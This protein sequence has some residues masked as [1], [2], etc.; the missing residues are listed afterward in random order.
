MPVIDIDRET[1]HEAAQRELANPIYP[2]A[3]LSDRIAEWFNDLLYRLMHTGT[4]L[5]GGWFTM[6]VLGLLIL[7]ALIVAVRIA[8]RTMGRRGDDPLHRSLMLSA[9]D[10]RERAEH[11]AAQQDWATAIRQRLRAVSRQLEEDGVLNPVPGRTAGE[12]AQD[13]GGMMPTYADDLVAAAAA[14]DDVTYGR[15]PGTEPQYRLIVG[16]DD[17]VRHH[18]AGRPA[19]D[20]PA[21]AR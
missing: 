7:A 1:A 2:R 12:L 18:S 8:R 13:A 14:F 4:A 9:A 21:S 16:L 3:S 10:H 5:P 15:R 11:A 6:V 20:T 19:D 17:R